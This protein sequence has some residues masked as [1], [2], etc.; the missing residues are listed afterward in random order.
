MAGSGGKGI[1]VIQVGGLYGG[2]ISLD[3]VLFIVEEEVDG[4][5]ADQ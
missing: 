5:G 1:A 2:R 4:T 3:T